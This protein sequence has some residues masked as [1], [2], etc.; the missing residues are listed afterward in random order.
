MNRPRL[1]YAQ[2]ITEMRAALV[3]AEAPLTLAEIAA[4]C[5][6]KPSTVAVGCAMAAELREERVT[7]EGEAGSYR[8][9][10]TDLG[11]AAAANPNV[12]RR[13]RRRRS[14]AHRRST[15][16]TLLRESLHGSTR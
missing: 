13:G 15:L 16:G 12:L 4:R 8:Y 9:R 1:P 5:P 11:R 10:I 14:R 3:R 7:R 2:R 6:S